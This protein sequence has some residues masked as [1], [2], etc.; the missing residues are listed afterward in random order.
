[1][2]VIYSEALRPPRPELV[3]K[4]ELDPAVAIR[5]ISPKLVRN[6]ARQRIAS[7][8][9][10]PAGTW[11]VRKANYLY[12]A[13][14]G[15]TIAYGTDTALNLPT[16]DCTIVW[17]AERNTSGN[18]QTRVFGRDDATTSNR[19][20]CHWPWSDGNGYVDYA[21]SAVN[22]LT[23][24]NLSSRFDMTRRCV[25]VFRF[26]S[27]GSFVWVN[28]RLIGSNTGD[29]G[30]RANTGA[31]FGIGLHGGATY[32]NGGWATEA[33]I[34]LRQ[35]FS[36]ARSAKISLNPYGELLETAHNVAFMPAAVAG[37]FEPA[38]AN[39]STVTLSA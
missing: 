37:G 30:T 16:R 17:I 20:G 14:T 25:H 39:S 31:N 32:H 11:S 38:W 6:T 10:V 22:R 15:D 28:G 9:M 36:N 33:F 12:S 19:I 21:S 34:V 24:T 23:I 26:S 3:L 18:A 29:P 5:W 4:D 13:S 1:M 35:A 27:A 8:D 7:P 2:S